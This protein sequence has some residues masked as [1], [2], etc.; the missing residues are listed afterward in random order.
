MRVVAGH[1]SPFIV[2]ERTTCDRPGVAPMGVVRCAGRR[3][4]ALPGVA[5]LGGPADPPDAALAAPDPLV[6]D[7]LTAA[8]RTHRDRAGQET[9]LRAST[10]PEP[11]QLL[12][13]AP[14]VQVCGAPPSAAGKKA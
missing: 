5:S 3:R 12:W 4:V 1:F 7:V 11:N 10:S 8:S 14:P 13:A 6:V 9:A 2:L